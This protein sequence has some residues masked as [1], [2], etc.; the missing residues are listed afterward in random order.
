MMIIIVTG[1]DQELLLVSLSL[2][3]RIAIIGGR[4]EARLTGAW[5]MMLLVGPCAKFPNHRSHGGL[6]G[7]NFPSSLLSQHLPCI[8]V[9][10]IQW[11]ML[12]ILIRE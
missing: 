3:M 9:G 1:P 12:A 8:M 4:V 5:G 10:R 6:K 11:S 2:V 7:E